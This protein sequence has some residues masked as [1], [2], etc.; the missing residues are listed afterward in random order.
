MATALIAHP[1]TV[2]QYLEFEGYP[3]LKDEL[4]NGR[5]VLSPQPKPHHQQVVVNFYDSL[6]DQL[7]G[8]DY[9][10]QMNSNIRFDQANSMPAPDV[11]IT[12]RSVWREAIQNETYLKEPPV[13]VV[14]VLS[15]ANRK[16]HVNEKAAL[17]LAHGVQHIL[18]ANPKQNQLF[19]SRWASESERTEVAL[20]PIDEIALEIGS[21]RIALSSHDVFQI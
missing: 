6:R 5:I 3:G 12:S 7:R 11:F 17:Y 8:S 9:T 20:E 10:V 16:K 15:P 13:L 14:E 19:V 2:E 1:I 21:V 18:I 4:I